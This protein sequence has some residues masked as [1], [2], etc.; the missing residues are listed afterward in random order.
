MKHRTSGFKRNVIVFYD[1]PLETK[2]RLILY[3]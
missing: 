2:I 1:N 3:Y